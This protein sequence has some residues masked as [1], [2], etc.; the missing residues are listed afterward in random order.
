MELVV[1]YFGYHFDGALRDF[2]LSFCDQKLEHHLCFMTAETEGNFFQ[3][4]IPVSQWIRP[5]CRLGQLWLLF[6]T[7]FGNVVIFLYSFLYFVCFDVQLPTFD[8]GARLFLIGNLGIIL[9]VS[10]WVLFASKT[11]ISSGRRKSCLH[12]RFVRQPWW[13]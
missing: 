8:K 6:Q 3:R 10:W 4:I 11:A 13:K 7:P 9:K 2:Q 12:K 5:Q 1:L